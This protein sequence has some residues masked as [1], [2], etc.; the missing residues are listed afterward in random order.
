M[1]RFSTGVEDAAD[2]I[3]VEDWFQELERTLE[4]R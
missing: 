2:L 3:V 1:L 4:G